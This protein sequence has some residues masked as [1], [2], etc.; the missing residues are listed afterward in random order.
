MGLVNLNKQR[1]FFA[2]VVLKLSTLAMTLNQGK[3]SGD[4]LHSN[5]LEA[6]TK[7]VLA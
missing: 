6:R 5:V 3:N 4:V 2:V 1:L 7:R